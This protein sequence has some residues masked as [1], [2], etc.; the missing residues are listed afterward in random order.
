MRENI[1]SYWFNYCFITEHIIYLMTEHIICLNL[2]NMICF[3]NNEDDNLVVSG[4][5]YF[6]IQ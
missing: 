2:E 1:R 3:K 4:W 5:L 6:D